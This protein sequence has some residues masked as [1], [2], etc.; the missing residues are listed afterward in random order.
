MRP[1]FGLIDLSLDLEEGSGAG[2]GEGRHQSRY[3]T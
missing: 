1:P 2:F 3:G